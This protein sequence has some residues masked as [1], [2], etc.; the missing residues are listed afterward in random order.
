MLKD[1]LK[2][3]E[4]LLLDRIFT[5][6]QEE[7]RVE[8]NEKKGEL[9]KVLQEDLERQS[10]LQDPSSFNSFGDYLK[11]FLEQNRISLSTAAWEYGLD[12]ETFNN[13]MENRIPLTE[14]SPR[15]L[16]KLSKN[17]QLAL[18]SAVMLIEK[19]LKLYAL[20]PSS[21]G[22]MARYSSKQGMDKK[23]QSMKHGVAELMMRAVE[24]KP[25]S[26]KQHTMSDGAI[27]SF[28][29]DFKRAFS[30]L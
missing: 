8:Y 14:V 20:S 25:F 4:A 15:T 5:R 2:T 23:T 9:V 1:K 3:L 24:Q 22:A 27:R 11:L 13:V 29:E 26:S 16:A 6:S 19:S 28:L 10:K 17:I 12:K 18:G 7:V 30:S 21:K